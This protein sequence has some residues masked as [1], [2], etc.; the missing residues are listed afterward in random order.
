MGTCP[1]VF[2]AGQPDPAVWR[3]LGTPH[4]Q[5][6]RDPLLRRTTE[7]LTQN[8]VKLNVMLVSG[9]ARG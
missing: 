4:H 8:A 5:C 7:G 1:L 6:V 3:I 2:N 9:V